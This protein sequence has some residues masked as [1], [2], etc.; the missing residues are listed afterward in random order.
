MDYQ[1]LK[2]L[3]LILHEK[4]FPNIPEK[5][6][7]S[8]PSL[9]GHFPLTVAPGGLS[10]TTGDLVGEFS[11]PPPPAGDTLSFISTLETQVVTKTC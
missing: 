11:N 2:S 1:I 6:I 5:P 3:E 7:S 8:I 10:K 4:K 9:P